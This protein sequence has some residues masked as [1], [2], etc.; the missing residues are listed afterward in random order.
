MDL[1]PSITHGE[2]VA[3]LASLRTKGYKG[4]RSNHE[5]GLYLNTRSVPSWDFGL[6]LRVWASEPN[7]TLFVRLDNYP[8]TFYVRHVGTRFSIAPK[9][10]IVLGQVVAVPY[11]AMNN[12]IAEMPQLVAKV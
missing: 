1:T 9:G 8:E 7:T 4:L 10:L 11:V 5:K 12:L 6:T 3:L 2:F